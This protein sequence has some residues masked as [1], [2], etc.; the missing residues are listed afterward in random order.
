MD[1]VFSLARD[2]QIAFDNCHE[3]GDL[4]EKGDAWTYDVWIEPGAVE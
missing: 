2:V 4:M 3:N 1:E